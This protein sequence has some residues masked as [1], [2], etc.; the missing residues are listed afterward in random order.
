MVDHL[1]AAGFD[2]DTMLAAGLARTTRSGYLV[3][4]F[5]DRLTF[6][7]HDID[8]RPVGFVAR[9][10]AADPK[11]ISSPS[12]RIY[13]KGRSLVGIDAQQ[14]RLARGAVPVVVEGPTDAVAVSLLGAEWAGASSCG[15][16]ITRHQAAIVRRFAVGDTVILMLD[17]DLAG[18]Q[19]ALRGL[20]ALSTYFRTVLVAE[21]PG[22]HD[23]AS[24]FSTSRGL[25][26]AVLTNA[27]PGVEFAIDVELARWGKVLDHLS[28]QVEALRSVAPMVVKLPKDRIAG[29]VVR[30]ARHLHLEER[31]VSREILACVGRRP[32]AGAS[33]SD[34]EADPDLASRS[35]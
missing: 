16:A 33:P 25:M 31:V 12:T 11:Y 32:K 24:L 1:R 15:T 27:R 9:A 5:R 21:L 22:G 18:Q 10:R 4:R 7:A 20:D 23:P 28:G 3:D 34:M 2:D 8:L 6:V 17:G 14:A 29:Q 19:G 13:A 35:P 26:R 30:L